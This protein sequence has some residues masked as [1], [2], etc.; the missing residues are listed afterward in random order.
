MYKCAIMCII[1][2]QPFSHLFIAWL[3]IMGIINF[4]LFQAVA[5]WM[6]QLQS[7]VMNT[8]PSKKVAFSI[9]NQISSMWNDEEVYGIRHIIT[10]VKTKTENSLW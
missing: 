9:Y 2:T 5:S 10:A 7:A 6:K 1:Q 8:N 4:E 3:L